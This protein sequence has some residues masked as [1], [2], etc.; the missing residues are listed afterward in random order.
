MIA[1]FFRSTYIDGKSNF[2]HGKLTVL[3]Q[4]KETLF[5]NNDLK[6]AAIKHLICMLD[7]KQMVDEDWDI[8]D[9]Y[10]LTILDEI[11]M[12]MSWNSPTNDDGKRNIETV[13]TFIKDSLD[14]GR[15]EQYE[16]EGLI[17]LKENDLQ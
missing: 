9:K 8:M 11:G 3:I 2:E 12:L 17:D 13:A 6:L 16:K 15:L 4:G 1:I 10:Y 14:S 7:F 5:W